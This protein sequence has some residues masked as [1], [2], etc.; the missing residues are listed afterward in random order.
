M[1]RAGLD[2]DNFMVLRHLW[3]PIDSTPFYR[4]PMALIRFKFLLRCM[5]F[6]NDRNQT[7]RQADDRL[8]AI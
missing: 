5:R 7:G 8:E 6:D 3:D 1:I 4:V 2:R